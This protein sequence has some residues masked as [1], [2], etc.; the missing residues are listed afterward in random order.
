MRTLKLY[1]FQLTSSCFPIQE[2]ILGAAAK[3]QVLKLSSSRG[4]TGGAQ[5]KRQ[6]LSI[7]RT[8]SGQD[9]FFFSNAILFQRKREGELHLCSMDQGCRAFSRPQETNLAFFLNWLASKFDNFLSGLP[10]F[11]PIE[12][13][14]VNSKIF[15]FLKQRLA[16]FSWKLLATLTS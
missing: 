9:K 14:I 10:F 6:D 2:A 5:P 16:F 11:K 4:G 7:Y 13:Y 12:V 8:P 15:P 3:S 1:S